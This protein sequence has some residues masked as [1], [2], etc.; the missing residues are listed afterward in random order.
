[1]TLSIHLLHAVDE[2]MHQFAFL[3][4]PTTSEFLQVPPSKHDKKSRCLIALSPVCSS[5]QSLQDMLNNRSQLGIRRMG[6][7]DWK[8]FQHM[9]SQKFPGLD[10]KKISAELCSKWQEKL[11]NPQWQPFKI[12]L[13][14]GEPQVCSYTFS[15][16][17]DL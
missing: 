1:M 12:V 13:K 6:E 11:R 17:C 15:C 2:K 9:C 7:I 4:L 5:M 16:L 8:P 10:C 3:F 14:N